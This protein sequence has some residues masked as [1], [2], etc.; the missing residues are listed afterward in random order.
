MKKILTLMLLTVAL[1]SNAQST[2]LR[3]NYT[4]GD[5][6]LVKM[7]MV[8]NMAAAGVFMNM[9]IEMSMDIKD[10]KADTFDVEMK[11]K[12]MTMDMK[13]GAMNMSY[14]S[15]KKE[16]DLDEMGKQMKAQMDPMLSIT[17]F[18]TV[19]KLGKVLATKVEPDI[20]SAGQ[21]KNQSSG[22][23]FPE[24]AVKVG[25][26]WDI[27]K[28]EKGMVMKFTY[29]VKSISNDTVVLDVTGNVSS[30][31]KG[32]ISGEVIVDKKSGVPTKST[33]NMD[34]EVQ[35]QQMKTSIVMSSEK[36]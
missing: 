31:A 6:Y 36:M 35:G 34:L 10:K 1:V 22:I 3:L 14:D 5:T 20:P 16:A 29:K 21:F 18:S 13:Q 32:T 15:T 27:D 11:I 12:K 30:N 33:I 17:I 25:D 2:L 23:V 7:D 26:T 28:T 9:N 8:Q 19:N 4:K 24:K